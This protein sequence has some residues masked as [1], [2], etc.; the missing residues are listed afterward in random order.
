[1]LRSAEALSRATYEAVRKSLAS[2]YD[3]FHELLRH[4]DA[5]NV[6]HRFRGVLGGLGFGAADYHR[7]DETFS[8]GPQSRLM[9]AKLLLAAPD[10]ML[11]DEPSNHPD[12]DT[13]RWLEDYLAAQ[14]EGM[15]GVR[16]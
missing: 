14:P 7:P 4:H 16:P 13:T 2:R 9:R 12:I 3:R 1:M 11:L 10:V 6:D 5:F 15:P 8:G